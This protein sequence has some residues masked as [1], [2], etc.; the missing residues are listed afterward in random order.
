MRGYPHRR[1]RGSRTGAARPGHGAVRHGLQASFGDPTIGIEDEDG[2]GRL[3][4]EIVAGAGERETFAAARGILALDHDSPAGPREVGRAIGAVVGD[5]DQP[6][7]RVESAV[8][9]AVTVPA[10]SQ[11]SSWAGMT[12][13]RCAFGLDREPGLSGRNRRKPRPKIDQGQRRGITQSQTK[14]ATIEP[15]IP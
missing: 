13:A 3:R 9:A 6:G 5:H 7:C 15:L 2:I 12:M 1:T 10:I 8:R 4:R 11:A 14:R